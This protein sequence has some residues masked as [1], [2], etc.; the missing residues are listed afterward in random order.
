MNVLPVSC[1]VDQAAGAR[2]G[3]QRLALAAD[4]GQAQR[5]GTVQHRHDQALVEGHGDAEVDLAMADDRIGL[6]A[7]IQA[8]MPAQGAGHGLGDEVAQRELDFLGGELPVQ[9][10]ADGDELVD[11]DVDGHVDLGGRLLGLS[12]PLG[13]RLAHP[14]VRNALGRQRRRCERRARRL[15]GGGRSAGGAAGLAV[16]AGARS[17]HRASAGAAAGASAGA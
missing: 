15:W 11:A 6:E 12:H 7:G 8:G 13:D 17:R 2:R 4:L 1:S 5:I 3:G 14:A 9:L 10:L 16:E